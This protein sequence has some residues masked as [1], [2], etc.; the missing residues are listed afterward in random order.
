M[1]RVLAVD[2]DCEQLD[3]RALLLESA[4]HE[5]CRAAGAEEALS[6][7]DG[8][9]PEVVLMDLRLPHPE[10]G[11]F[12]IQELRRIRPTVR[13]VVL[14]GW[15]GNTEDIPEISMVDRFLRKPCNSQTLLALIQR[16]A[17]FALAV[18]LLGL[19]PAL[20]AETFSFQVS[21]PAE[22]VAEL[23][24]RSPGSNWSEPGREAA[25]AELNLPGRPAQHIV[26]FA[27][28]DWHLYPVFLG[29]FK[30]GQHTMSLSRHPKWSAPGSGLEVSGVRF[31]QVTRTDPYYGLL[32]H[33]PVLYARPNTI[34]RFSDVPVL[35]YCE[36]LT[37]KGL[38]L[39][40]YTA[41]FSNEDGGTSTR[42]LM[43]RWGRTTDIEYVYKVF[44]DSNHKP[45]RATIQA[46]GHKE[47]DFEGRR[48]A[49]H[50]LLM[51]VTENNMVSGEAG[52]ALRFQPAPLEVNLD[53]VSREQV[54]DDH[55][56]TYR[57]M[58][59]ELE[60][61]NKLRR[62]GVVDG[63]KISDPRNYLYIEALVVNRQARISP[64]LRL[65]GETRWWFAHLGRV[66]Y[67]VERDGWVR[68]AV[69]LPPGKQPADIA[70]VGF[71]CLVEP[72]TKEKP[73]PDAGVC[74]LDGVRR[75]FFLDAG[76]RPGA[77]VWS[78]PGGNSWNIPTG[79]LLIFSLKPGN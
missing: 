25:V 64:A 35:M 49:L 7:L 24:M 39:V 59:E 77:T 56:W 52:S 31:R 42:A 13:I 40:Q 27:G 14:S 32:A 47:V 73:S 48:E 19:H 34:G 68:I 65:S 55:P 6:C 21:E 4:G 53:G 61:E 2:D 9:A 74:R 36:R 23:T 10:Q 38:P 78:L 79:E 37:E 30:P 45:L 46:R 76:Y 57:V 16:L 63:Q 1:A 5:V 43:A 22:V 54:M 12:L 8:F 44:P 15:P 75:S 72:P 70:E 51:P 50:P 69:E 62:F 60:R 29:P 3:V 26:L 66:D 11:R 71:Q 58:A 33:A 67:A 17:I 20:A 28:A 18:F 41:I